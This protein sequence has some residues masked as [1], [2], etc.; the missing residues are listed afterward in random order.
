MRFLSLI[1]MSLFIYCSIYRFLDAIVVNDLN[2][3]C[4]M[5]AS[6][7]AKQCTMQKCL[8]MHRWA[9]GVFS[10]SGAN[11]PGAIGTKQYRTVSTTWQCA[12]AATC[13][14]TPEVN[15]YYERR[16][17]WESYIIGRAWF[18]ISI[19]DID[20]QE[21]IYRIFFAFLYFLSAGK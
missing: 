5:V 18:S 13:A 21:T 8:G 12:G 15:H 17:D 10:K 6:R 4:E 3:L 11:S 16:I 7:A 1:L 9:D 20:I 14:G 2:L 19:Y